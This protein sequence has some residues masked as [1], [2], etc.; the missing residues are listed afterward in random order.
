MLFVLRLLPPN[1]KWHAITI[2]IALA[3]NFMVTLFATIS[4]G[5]SCI[6]FRANWDHVPGAKCLSDT[7]IDAAQI[8]NGGMFQL[9]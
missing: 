9:S 3:I 4:Y 1:K 7:F 8:A 6:P 5:L 2:Y